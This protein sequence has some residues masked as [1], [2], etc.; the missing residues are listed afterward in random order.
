MSAEAIMERLEPAVR[1]GI[2]R[3]CDVSFWYGLGDLLIG[4][5]LTLSILVLGFIL[6]KHLWTR[7]KKEEDG[8]L[9]VGLGIVFLAVSG[10]GSLTSSC[11]FWGIMRLSDPMG[12]LVFEAI[13][14]VQS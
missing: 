9:L 8:E 13:R 10:F 5:F 3:A 2:T 7:Y 14:N 6:M 4:F 1:E 11:I 12:T